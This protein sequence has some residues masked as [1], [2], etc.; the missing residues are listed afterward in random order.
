MTTETE[1]IAA[2]TTTD[3]T[4]AGKCG[5]D[6][7]NVTKLANEGVKM[8]LT[9]PDG[10]ATDEFLM[11]CGA[12]SHVFR[13][14]QAKANRQLLKLAKNQK[15]DPDKA[16]HQRQAIQRGLVAVLVVDWSFDEECSKG[17]V[18]R[19]F[20]ASPQIQMEVDNFAGNRTHF[21]AKPSS[22]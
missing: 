6:A 17:A 13:A 20:E 18:M 21:F 8:P 4:G 2:E 9:L 5:M 11:V 22:T 19:F 10:T 15:M 1:E 3:N 12:D 14:E 16:E 7:F